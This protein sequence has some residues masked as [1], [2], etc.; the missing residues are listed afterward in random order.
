MAPPPQP[1]CHQHAQESSAFPSRQDVPQR[2][3]D[4]GN[5]CG[6]AQV[7]EFKAAS[8]SKCMLQWDAAEIDFQSASLYPHA[9]WKT[10]LTRV[11]A[12]PPSPPPDRPFVLRV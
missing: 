6:Q 8:I 1:A 9:I 11:D 2:E 3:H 5:P 4:K 10:F 7:F 12:L